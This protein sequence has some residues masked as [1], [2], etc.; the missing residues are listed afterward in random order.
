MF[1]DTDPGFHYYV[2][3]LFLDSRLLRSSY[4]IALQFSSKLKSEFIFVDIA[5]P[6]LH[7]AVAR[8]IDISSGRERRFG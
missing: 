5:V 3:L 8:A 7:C 1:F 4:C 2:S 6:S